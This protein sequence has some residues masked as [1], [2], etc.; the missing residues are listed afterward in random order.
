MKRAKYMGNEER[1]KGGG[2]GKLLVAG[3][4]SRSCFLKT[5]KV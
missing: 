5:G 1:E 2:I 3:F 4:R